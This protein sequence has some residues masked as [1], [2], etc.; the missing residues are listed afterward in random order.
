[1]PGTASFKRAAIAGSLFLLA[2]AAVVIGVDRS[3]GGDEP[4][5][6]PSAS[7]SL[8]VYDGDAHGAIV[9]RG[10]T[11]MG[12]TASGTVRWRLPLGAHDLL[13]YATCLRVCPEA[14][15]TVARSGSVP[16][17]QP[18]GPRL[19]FRAPAWRSVSQRPRLRIDRPLAAATVPARIVAG[20]SGHATVVLSGADAALANLDYLTSM[21]SNRGW[22]VVVERRPG[23]SQR[24]LV[25]RRS[26]DGWRLARAIAIGRGTQSA[27]PRLT[28]AVSGSWAAG[29]RRSSISHPATRARRSSAARALRSAMPACARWEARR[30]PLR[31]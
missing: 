2:L 22:A 17:D 28:G 19:R 8:V 15:V 11:M 18:D 25:L 24:A 31:S 3:G 12:V 20:P 21:S 14:E 4:P 7:Q 29:G 13:P 27:C 30:W 6:P 10:A 26:G 16:P 1:V 5:A 9:V 23:G